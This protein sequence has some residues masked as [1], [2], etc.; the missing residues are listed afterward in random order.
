ELRLGQAAVK[1]LNALLARADSD[2]RVRGSF[3][4]HGAST[5]RWSG[6]GAQPQNLKRPEIDDIDAAIAAVATGDPAHVKKLYPKP[7][8]VIG[9]CSRSMITAPPGHTLIGAD[10]SSIESRVLAWIATEEWK[11]NSYRR[12]DATHDPLDEPYC[13]TACKI[14]HVPDGTYTKESPER[15]IGK[16]ADLALGYQGGVNA[17][18]KFEAEQFS[19]EEIEQF[20]KEWRAG[21]PGRKQL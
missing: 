11:L 5:G 16:I 12:F 2:D 21:Q 8:S 3:K 4:Y 13:I 17:F 14:F 6:E 18:K 20:K 7:L 19:D 9:D 15:G 10:F 1:K